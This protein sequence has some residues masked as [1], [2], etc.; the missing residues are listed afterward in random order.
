MQTFYY[1]P[2]IRRDIYDASCRF[3]VRCLAIKDRK[4]NESVAAA[5]AEEAVMY[6]GREEALVSSKHSVRKL[7]VER[8]CT[9]D[10]MHPQL[11]TRS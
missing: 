4:R 5:L 2:T 1:R 9:C 10:C 7:G 6:S 8:A 11:I 3:H